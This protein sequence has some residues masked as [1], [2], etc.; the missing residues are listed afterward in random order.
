MNEERFQHLLDKKN[1]M[2]NLY[3]SRFLT[4]ITKHHLKVAQYGII[5]NRNGSASEDKLR[6]SFHNKYFFLFVR[7]ENELW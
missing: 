2:P 1:Q 4:E 3:N 6:S 7:F 5:S